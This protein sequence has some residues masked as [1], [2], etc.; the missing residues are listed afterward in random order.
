MSVNTF[1][2]DTIYVLPYSKVN[3]CLSKNKKASTWS[4]MNIAIDGDG[5]IVKNPATLDESD[6]YYL[7]KGKLSNTQLV[8]GS[9]QEVNLSVEMNEGQIALMRSGKKNKAKTFDGL[10]ITLRVHLDWVTA[11]DKKKT[12]STKENLLINDKKPIK[13]LNTNADSIKAKNPDGS[14]NNLGLAEINSLTLALE[15][16]F[17]NNKGGFQ[18]IFAS[19]NINTDKDIEKSSFAWIQPTS[20]SYAVVGTTVDGDSVFY[21]G[22]L[23]MTGGRHAP[24][25]PQ[26]PGNAIPYPI[27]EEDENLARINSCFLVS[28]ERFLE[29]LLLPNLK[30]LFN[31]ATDDDFQVSGNIISN[32]NELTFH[33][34]ELANGKI[35]NPTSGPGNF[36][37]SIQ[38]QLLV[39][40]MQ[41]EFEYTKGYTVKL[42]STSYSTLKMYMDEGKKQVSLKFL[43]SNMSVDVQMAA[44]VPIASAAADILVTIGTAL[45]AS[46]AETGLS[47]FN[48]K[49]DPIESVKPSDSPQGRGRTFQVY[50]MEPVWGEELIRTTAEDSGY[51]PLPDGEGY[52]RPATDD[53]PQET[54]SSDQMTM[55]VRRQTPATPSDRTAPGTGAGEIVQ[56]NT[57]S[58]SKPIGSIFN[59]THAKV[60]GVVAFSLS[61]GLSALTIESINAYIDHQTF[62][63]FRNLLEKIANHIEWTDDDD[64][65]LLA[66]Y[67]DK[68]VQF[69]MET[70]FQ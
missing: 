37:I 7:V 2:W 31:G 50:T 62:P 49:G 17:S 56:Q 41:C 16:Y 43:S 30:L 57:T 23:C 10:N 59:R 25:T 4:E 27:L 70:K 26:I 32:I 45:I 18:T 64:H 40:S 1:G 48:S 51:K 35:V 66:I 68:A 22:V 5:N 54:V 15:S 38:D 3:E 53:K 39:Q 67:L 63:D 36:S 20:T 47:C 34:Q 11:P 61:L 13:I 46:V 19:V 28:E 60:A 44:W 6:P 8:G 21:F 24:L 14:E 69:A 58:D 12:T 52:R 9:G 33:N 29:N 42:S 65:E 55:A